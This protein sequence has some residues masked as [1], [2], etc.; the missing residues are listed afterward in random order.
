MRIQV[1]NL[2]NKIIDIIFWLCTII[3]LWFTAQIFVLTSFK[4]PSDS[5]EPQLTAGDNIL[6]WKPTI[7]PR[8]FNLFASMRNEQTNIY[9]IPG[10]KK[11]QRNDI[12]VFNFP[13]P[14]SW[15]KIE[16]HIL[17]YYIKRCVGLPGDTLSIQ[18]GF[19]HVKGIETSLGNMESQNKIATTEQFEDGIF[20]SFPFDS[21][22]SWNIKDFGPLYIPG[23][24]DSITLNQT[25]CRLYK[26]LIEWEQQGSLQY[27]DSTIF[28]NGTPINGYRF[29]K[30][31]YFMAG[32]NGMNSQ[33]SRY[34]G[35]LPEEYIV[36]KAWII[37]KSVD[38]YT[39]KFR[40]NRFL[41]VIH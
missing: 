7:G 28:L 32:D 8:I 9:R 5:M 12:L 22:I 18:N 19:F 24:G 25:N 35:L 39:D 20:H 23:K 16:M 1:H 41:K 6:V 14:N 3:A 33:D 29:Q 13:H 17:K 2:I 37:W 21:I 30:N 26:K 27:K 38:P 15:D 11:I 34:W 36:G 4:I 31:Y 10:I 40:W